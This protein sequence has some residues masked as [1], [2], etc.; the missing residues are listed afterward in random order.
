MQIR[1]GL[2]NNIE[3]RSLAW[4]LDHPGCFAYGKDGPEGNITE[5]IEKSCLCVKLEEEIVEHYFSA[6]TISSICKAREPF[7]STVSLGLSRTETY[8]I[9]FFL[10]SK[11]VACP[12]PSS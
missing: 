1:V 3:G 8:S 5:H 6:S 2:E 11:T 10:S 9:S 4:V 12:G 7:T